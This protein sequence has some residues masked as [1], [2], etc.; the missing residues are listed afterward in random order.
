MKL[1]ASADGVQSELVLP[2]PFEPARQPDKAAA[3]I[4][5]CFEKLGDTDW[6]LGE[7]T[8][9]GPAVFIP[10]S[11]LNDARRRLIEQFSNDW[12]TACHIFQ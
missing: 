8:L 5:Q 12:K 9:E 11:V 6:K 7:L 2:G 3:V 1:A 4:R 10:V